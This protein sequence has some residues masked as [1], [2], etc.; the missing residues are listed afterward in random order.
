MVREYGIPLPDEQVAK[1]KNEA[2]S[3]ADEIGYPVVMKMISDKHSHKSDIGG[4][5]VD[6]RN[7]QEVQDAWDAISEASDQ[8]GVEMQGALVQQMVTSGQEVIVGIKHDPEFGS[9][10]LFGTGGTDVELYNDTNTAIA[11]LCEM[12][13]QQL[14]AGT[15]AGRKFRGWRDL[16]KADIDAVKEALITMSY[17]AVHH[18]DITELE[19]NPLYVMKDGASVIAVDVRGSTD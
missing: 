18:P 1:S 10:I 13:A 2:V 4:V 3:V 8:H 15:I 11:P 14:I 9:M 17:L 5:R 6:L 16:P 7:R 19:I 12:E